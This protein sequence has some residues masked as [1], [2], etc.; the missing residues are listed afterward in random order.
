MA[1]GTCPLERATIAILQPRILLAD[2]E[3]PDV[4]STPPAVFPGFIKSLAGEALLD[5]NGGDGFHALAQRRIEGGLVATH[6]IVVAVQTAR[7]DA[8]FAGFEASAAFVLT[9]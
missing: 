3:G 4:G 8:G 5:G 6:L 9:A 7:L 1:M 2:F